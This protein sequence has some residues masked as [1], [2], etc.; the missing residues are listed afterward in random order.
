[1]APPV[2]KPRTR[3][4]LLSLAVAALMVTWTGCGGSA[5]KRDA[6]KLKNKCGVVSGQP[7]TADEARCIAMLFGVKDKGS[8]PV[9]ID[10]PDEFSEPVYRVRESCNDLG[11]LVAKSSVPETLSVPLISRVAPTVK[12]PEEITS[13]VPSMVKVVVPS[14]VRVP[15]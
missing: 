11:V 13:P 5:L 3:L 15:T 1:M 6:N 4:T 8:C 7:V 2:M 14:S 10:E 12:P 9:E